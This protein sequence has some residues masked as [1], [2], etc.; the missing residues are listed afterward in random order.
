[1]KI[2]LPALTAKELR[3]LLS[4]GWACREGRNWAKGKSL[5]DAWRT[6]KRGDWMKWLLYVTAGRPR[7]P[8]IATYDRRR[9]KWQMP[10]PYRYTPSESSFLARSLK[11]ARLIRK[12]IG[13]SR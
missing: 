4:N 1:M 5:A 2:L 7:W 3:V 12:E 13:V 10:M 11:L 6:C 9:K 8:S